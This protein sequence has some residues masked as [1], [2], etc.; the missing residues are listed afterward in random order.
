MVQNVGPPLTPFQHLITPIHRQNLDA[1]SYGTEEPT[2]VEVDFTATCIAV[3]KQLAEP[4]IASGIFSHI[5]E[6]LHA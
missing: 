6:I 3:I 1:L 4:N 5:E 2:P